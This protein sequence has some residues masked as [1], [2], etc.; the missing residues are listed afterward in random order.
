[1]KQIVYVLT[2]A[3]RVLAVFAKPELPLTLPADAMVV[4]PL[5]TDQASHANREIVGQWSSES[6]GTMLTLRAFRLL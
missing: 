3:D 4:V 5:N 1:M 2:E 6:F